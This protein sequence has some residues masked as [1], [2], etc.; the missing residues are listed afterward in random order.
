M[1]RNFIGF[2]A[3][4]T[5][6]THTRHPRRTFSWEMLNFYLQLTI[7]A[8]LCIPDQSDA[9]LIKACP[10]KGQAQKGQAQKGQ[11]ENDDAGKMFR[12][13][14]FKVSRSEPRPTDFLL[15]GSQRA[16]QDERYRCEYNPKPADFQGAGHGQYGRHSFWG[17]PPEW[18]TKGVPE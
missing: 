14:D 6:Y 18:H 1:L 12:M 7:L 13:C 16:D 10:P 17:K 8:F 9:W 2:V 11:A 4:G 3:S 15:F 5:R